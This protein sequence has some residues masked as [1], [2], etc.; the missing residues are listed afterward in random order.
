MVPLFPEKWIHVTPPVT[1]AH[2][3]IYTHKNVSLDILY[4][5]F[6][7]SRWEKAEKVPENAQKKHF[8]L[9]AVTTHIFH[10]GSTGAWNRRRCSKFSVVP[11]LNMH[12]QQLIIKY[13]LYE[14]QTF[15]RSKHFLRKHTTEKKKPRQWWVQG[16]Q[17]VI[18]L[19]MFLC[20]DRPRTAVRKAVRGQPG[21]PALSLP[22]HDTI[23]ARHL[24]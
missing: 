16:A 15:I 17:W 2:T 12:R 21:S 14:P 19:S 11:V 13:A 3:Q 5:G 22:I 1:H 10:M 23:L 24:L 8:S 18:L 4:K 6:F 7:Y 9:P 20:Y